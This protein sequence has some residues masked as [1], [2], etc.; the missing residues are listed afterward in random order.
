M[1]AVLR[2]GLGLLALGMLVVGAWNQFWPE[3]FYTDFPGADGL[4]PSSRAPC[5]SCPR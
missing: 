5:W 4:P 2:V 1:N 3:S